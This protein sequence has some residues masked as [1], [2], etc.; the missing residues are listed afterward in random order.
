MFSQL[1]VG[2]KHG[3]DLVAQGQNGRFTIA[4]IQASA[5]KMARDVPDDVFT[6]LYGFVSLL[7]VVD[8]DRFQLHL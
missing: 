2:E 8:L 5:R 7:G 3:V 1:S 4:L 6:D